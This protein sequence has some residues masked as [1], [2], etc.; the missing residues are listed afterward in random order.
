MKGVVVESGRFTSAV[1]LE[2][3]RII[4]RPGAYPPGR[5]LEV[6]RD[7]AFGAPRLCM[8]ACAALLTAGSLFALRSW[9]Y[10]VQA[11]SYISVDDS[12]SIEYA[13]N[14]YGSVIAVSAVDEVS[15]E[16]AELLSEKVMNKK[17]DEALAIYMDELS[18]EENILL[19]SVTSADEDTADS[20][21]E[22]IGSCSDSRADSRIVISKTSQQEREEAARHGLSAGRYRAMRQDEGNETRISGSGSE[23][24]KT[25][26]IQNR[27]E[28]REIPDILSGHP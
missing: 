12:C 21:V 16:A 6:H 27:S 8:A 1:L 26:D 18:D 25:G 10:S 17:A 2:D 9:Q 4:R 23:K 5:I 24:Q 7:P 11:Y 20:L 19:V 13:L 3:G 28:I 22:R 14:R 15:E